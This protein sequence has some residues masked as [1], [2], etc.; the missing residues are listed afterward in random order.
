[1]SRKIVTVAIVLLLGSVNA[2][3]V[4][5][6]P[7]IISGRLVFTKQI[8]AS[9]VDEA[10]S[11]VTADFDGDGDLDV[12]ATD[13]V[14][15]TLFWYENDGAG[16]FLTHVLDADLDGAYPSSVA[17]VDLDGD[18]DVLACGYEGDVVAWYESDGSGGFTRHDVDAA[19]DGAHSVVTGDLDEDGD[20]DLLTT[21]QDAG[22]VNWYENDGSQNFTLH[23]I[24]DT[25][26]DAKRAEF[27]DIDGD[28]DLDIVAASFTVNEI[29]W[30]ENDGNQ[31]FT[32]Q[33]VD[34]TVNGAYY[35]FPTD[36][37]GDGDVDVLTASQLDNSIRLYRNDGAGQFVVQIIDADAEGARMVLAA[38]ID[39]DGD[40]DPISS[41]VDDDTVGWYENL[42]DGYFAQRAVDVNADAAYGIWVIDFDKDG[43]IDVLSAGRDDYIVALY[44]QTRS[45][46]AYLT[47]LGG[48][49]PINA[50]L[51]NT[52]DADDIPLELTYTITDGPDSGE[53]RVDGGVVPL[54]GTFTQDDIDHNRL[55]YVHDGFISPS[56]V[57]SFTVSDGGQ[58]GFIPVSGTFTIFIAELRLAR[59]PLDETSGQVAEDIVGGYDGTLVGG[60][61][62]QP[63]GGPIM[64]ALEFD[65]VD[66]YVDIGAIGFAR[67][68]G[69]TVALWLRPQALNGDSR[70]ISKATGISEQDHYLMVSTYLDTKLRFRLKAGGVTS[71]LVTEQNE[72]EIDQWYHV[73]CT[74]DHNE[75][76]IYG[77]GKLV[78]SMPKTGAIDM[79]QLV[80][81]AI[82]AQPP[83]AGSNNFK[84]MID[85]VRLY[86]FALSELEIA[87][88]VKPRALSGLRWDHGCKPDLGP[89]HRWCQFYR[90]LAQGFR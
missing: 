66:D 31:N 19:A 48:T 9:D 46:Q 21:N 37:D 5:H 13:F 28:N 39:G 73:A 68:I 84:G 44:H 80:T 25:A 60:P 82:G 65:G 69:M 59:W 71:T 18:T 29:A 61:V 1:M 30:Y 41:S 47:D 64:G 89:S 38:D 6:P 50:T 72:L 63:D 22:T 12:V 52:I 67:D 34:S 32:K 45:H 77:N 75:M 88:L 70:L 49:L 86:D 85:D 24:D 43:D 42:G 2:F 78:A 55:T 3:G 8:I 87:D 76:H 15:D 90:N 62:W 35:V 23:L 81:A 26:V 53:L 51:L 14:D 27:A 10:H 7:Q 56:D 11:V 83:G 57:F 16:G 74:Y 4:N 54:G 20:I 36:I 17:D 33:V 79:D 40:L 58:D